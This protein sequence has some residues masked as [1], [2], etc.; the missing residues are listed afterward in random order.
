MASHAPIIPPKNDDINKVFSGIRQHCIIAFA[1][2][3]PNRMNV[4]TFI[5]NRY[6]Q[7]N[8]SILTYC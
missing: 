5:D 7:R 4:I 6:T 8:F 3:I 1:L 2:S